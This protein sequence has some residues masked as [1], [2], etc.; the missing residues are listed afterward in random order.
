MVTAMPKVAKRRKKVTRYHLYQAALASREAPASTVYG[1]PNLKHHHRSDFGGHHDWMIYPR[2]N[3]DQRGDG[4][5]LN[6]NKLTEM[7]SLAC[8]Q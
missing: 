1:I 3:M 5:S 4:L 2:G 8:T 6:W 7:F